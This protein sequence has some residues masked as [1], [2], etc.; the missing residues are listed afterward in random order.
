[1]WLYLFGVTP[2]PLVSKL[3]VN[4]CL[5]VTLRSAPGAT[6]LQDVDVIAVMFF[7]L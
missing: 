1:M 6:D 3:T 7:Y 4:R 2:E 5:S